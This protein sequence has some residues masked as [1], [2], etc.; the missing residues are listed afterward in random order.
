MES[1][2]IILQSPLSFAG[3]ARRIWRL[4]DTSWVQLF[5]LVPVIAMTWLLIC[6]WYVFAIVFFGI[7]FLAWRLI[8]RRG[9]EKKVDAARHREVLAALKS[10]QS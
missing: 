5:V 4:S 6:V 8:R 7:F 2:K 3:S 1:E 9:R 10:N